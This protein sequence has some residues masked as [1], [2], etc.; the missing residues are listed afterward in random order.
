MNMYIHAHTHTHI[1]IY[2]YIH[3]YS[4]QREPNIFFSNA[5]DLPMLVKSSLLFQDDFHTRAVHLGERSWLILQGWEDLTVLQCRISRW[6]H[7]VRRARPFYLA[8]CCWWGWSSLGG[9]GSWCWS[10]GKH[11][12]PQSQGVISLEGW[13][14]KQG[15]CC[16]LW[17]LII[18][19]MQTC[20]Y[21]AGLRQSI[22]FSNYWVSG[23]FDF[24][25]WAWC[26]LWISFL[27]V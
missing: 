22:G 15:R 1:Y 5:T 25:T 14:G 2:T 11:G 10:L 13:R 23:H 3:T 16:W 8:R 4:D 6:M 18:E 17:C 7:P 12:D 26:V 19:S 21:G 27:N 20:L 24:Y 9:D